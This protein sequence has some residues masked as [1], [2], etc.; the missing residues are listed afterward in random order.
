MAFHVTLHSTAHEKKTVTQQIVPTRFKVKI[1]Q[2]NRLRANSFVSVELWKRTKICTNI[3]EGPI[4]IIGM[5]YFKGRT[6]T[7]STGIFTSHQRLKTR[8]F[9]VT[10]CFFSDYFLDWTLPN[11]SLVDLAVVVRITQ[12]TLKIPDWL[13]N[14]LIIVI[15]VI[16]GVYYAKGREQAWKCTTMR[17]C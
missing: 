8:L 13:I 9:T 15:V 5:G 7:G 10:K 2:H 17:S 1:M 11:L 6:A 12:A 14:W 3:F 4:K 16:S